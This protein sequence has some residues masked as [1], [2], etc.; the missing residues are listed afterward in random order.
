MKAVRITL[1]LLL[2]LALSLPVFARGGRAAEDAALPTP[3][4]PTFKLFTLT[5]FAEIPH[6]G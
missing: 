4:V 5:R 2:T 1:V 3:I 6:F